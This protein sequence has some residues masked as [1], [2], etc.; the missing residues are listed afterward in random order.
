MLIC[1][2]I[3]SLLLQPVAWYPWI[4]KVRTDVAEWEVFSLNS[5]V[6]CW[7]A[8][9]SSPPPLLSHHCRCVTAGDVQLH[10]SVSF[11]FFF[12]VELHFFVWICSFGGW[13]HTRIPEPK[14]MIWIFSII[15]TIYFMFC[16]KITAELPDKLANLDEV[17]MKS[18][19]AHSFYPVTDRPHVSCW[20]EKHFDPVSL[21]LT[22][23]TSFHAASEGIFTWRHKIMRI[24][25]TL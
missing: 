4:T 12:H 20:E 11:T 8:A 23:S 5:L 9:M 3:A 21:T 19:S 2:Q 17:T 7:T 13:G 24:V 14:T 10:P 25:V 16:Q 6:C 22:N 15:L 18:F 1:S